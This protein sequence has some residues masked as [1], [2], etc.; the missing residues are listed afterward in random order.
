[1][2]ILAVVLYQEGEIFEGF[3]YVKALEEKDGVELI[4][5]NTRSDIRGN[6]GVIAETT[7]AVDKGCATC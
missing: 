1:M 5:H 7:E 2:T 3:N 4:I 6:R